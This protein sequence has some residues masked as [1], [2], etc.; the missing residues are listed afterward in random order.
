MKKFSINWNN[1]MNFLGVFG[2]LM[3]GIA[4]LIACLVLTIFLWFI[5]FPIFAVLIFNPVMFYLWS[6]IVPRGIAGMFYENDYSENN[7]LDEWAN[8]M[9]AIFGWLCRK[10]LRWEIN[11][12][13]WYA[14]KHFIKTRPTD[15]G[16]KD[17]VRYSRTLP[18]EE[19]TG[20]MTEFIPE[21]EDN[22]ILTA[23]KE[24][25]YDDL[26]SM[27]DMWINKALLAA[28]NTMHKP[29][30]KEEMQ[31][32]RDT[33]DLNT[34]DAYLKWAT[35]SEEHLKI[36]IVSKDI[37]ILERVAK[38]I[39][40]N[41][42]S[43]DFIAWATANNANC[44]LLT[45]N[46]DIFSQ[47]VLVRKHQRTADDQIIESWKRFCAGTADIYSEAQVEFNSIQTKVFYE[48]GHP[49][50]SEEAVFHFF[51]QAIKEKSDVAKIII[52]KEGEKALKSKRIKLLVMSNFALHSQILSLQ[53]LLTKSELS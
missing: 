23:K 37:E 24:A 33:G 28:K 7:P 51:S 9:V 46:I 41:G 4:I 3:K 20:F 42:V 21:N 27:R 12:L 14:K 13:P 32:L 40:C 11:L 6:L 26:W 53:G 45:K 1:V 18:E 29:F 19:K 31:Y 44:E 38:H 50:M 52:E 25:L 17:V 43:P 2:D 36:L 49:E 47:I 5:A 30:T 16:V 8:L 15:F 35:L 48:T 39:K 34:L 10:S 22:D